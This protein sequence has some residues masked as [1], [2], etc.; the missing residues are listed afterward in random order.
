MYEVIKQAASHL[1]ARY[2]SVNSINSCVRIAQIIY[3]RKRQRE[4]SIKGQ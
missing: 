1:L 2:I 3:D 4:E